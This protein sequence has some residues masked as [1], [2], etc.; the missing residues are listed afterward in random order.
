[1]RRVRVTMDRVHSEEREEEPRELRKR[2]RTAEKSSKTERQQCKSGKS[3][4]PQP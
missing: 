2:D 3:L 1:M 4:Q